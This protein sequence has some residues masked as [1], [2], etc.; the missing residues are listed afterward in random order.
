MMLVLQTNIESTSALWL[1]KGSSIVKKKQEEV[2]YPQRT[3]PLVL[4]DSVLR[5]SRAT[6]RDISKIIVTRGPGRFS[7]VR[8]GLLIANTLAQELRIPVHGVVRKILLSD[9]D[10]L[11]LC[12][13]YA[14]KKGKV[15]I[16]P[17]YGKKPN[18]TKAKKR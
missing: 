18:I 9:D 5:E 11:S 13:Q 1:V 8:V 12:K 7:S 6:P 14:G 15:A 2:E 4:L 3:T 16:K 10:V 17:W